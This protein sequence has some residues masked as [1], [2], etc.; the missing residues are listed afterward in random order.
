MRSRTYR[1]T[2]PDASVATGTAGQVVETCVTGRATA[3]RNE[4]IALIRDNRDFRY[5]WLG[6]VVSLLGDWF[7]LI[8]SAALIAS[9]TDSG[10]AIGSLFVVR[11]LAP[12]LVS[13]LAGVVADRYNRKRVL[14]LTD[15]VRAV[16]VLGFLLVREPSQVW[17]LY[18]LT[19]V[20][21][22][23]SGFFFP[24]RSAILPDI[25]KSQELGVANIIGAATWSVM[26]A[27]GA[28]L[29]GLV[30]G[31]WGNDIAFLMDSGTFALSAL[32][33]AVV[34]YTPPA[35]QGRTDKHEEPRSFV[36]QYVDG[37]RYLAR[38]RDILVVVLHK[39]MS[40]LLITSAMQV[41]QVDIAERLFVVGVGGS[42]GLGLMYGAAGIGT[43]IGPLFARRFTGDRIR[44]LGWGMSWGYALSILGLLTIASLQSFNIVVAGVALRG[45]G[46]GIIWVFSTQMLLQ[47]VPNRVRGRVFSTEFALFSLMSAIGAALTGVALDA[48]LTI[49]QI[50]LG[51]AMATV[52]PLLLWSW[53]LVWN[54]TT[55]AVD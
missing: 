9:L 30:A 11:M 26:L 18:T 34:R 43:G 19:A 6:Q 53:W 36:G 27:A 14:I 4:Y 55:G 54:R 50:T 10:L 47:M 31:T 24:T 13:P 29:G 44:A 17:L 1:L 40:A 5:L 20:Q 3:S 41:I 35:D 12:F 48:N 23:L 16:T 8:A 46:G 51:L 22:G 38:Q 45:I 28:A 2:P 42:V 49:T 52:I 33:I 7:N 21:L 39:A 37:L 25:V 32:L 15:V